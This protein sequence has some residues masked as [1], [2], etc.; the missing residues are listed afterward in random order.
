MIEYCMGLEK[1]ALGGMTFG[2]VISS[3]VG[4]CIITKF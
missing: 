1:V 3:L 4:H 2:P